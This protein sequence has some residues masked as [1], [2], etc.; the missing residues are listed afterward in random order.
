MAVKRGTQLSARRPV[1][2]RGAPLVQ[3]PFNRF[4]PGYSTYI[5]YIQYCL[6]RPCPIL[7]EFGI[8]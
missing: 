5:R 6:A 3:T 8:R 1:V 4:P 2:C 7:A